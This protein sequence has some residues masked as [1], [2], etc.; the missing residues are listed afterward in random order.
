ML[1]IGS[2]RASNITQK[3]EKVKKLSSLSF[4]ILFEGNL[5]MYEIISRRFYHVLSVAAQSGATFQSLLFQ[6]I[7]A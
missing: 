5:F 4:V 3:K 2:L 6:G 1:E 7:Y